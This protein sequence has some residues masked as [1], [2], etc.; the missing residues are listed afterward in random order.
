MLQLLTTVLIAAQER[1]FL[2]DPVQMCVPQETVIQLSLEG[3][4]SVDDLVDFDMDLLQQL[5]NNLRCIGG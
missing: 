2:E 3:F 5:A 4:E 1:L